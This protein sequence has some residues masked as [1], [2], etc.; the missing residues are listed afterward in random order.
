MDADTLN[1]DTSAISH[2]NARGTQRPDLL[3][4]I[5]ILLYKVFSVSKKQRPSPESTGV[6]DRDDRL[7]SSRSVVE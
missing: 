1:A 6:L 5:V 4:L 2:E 7:T 3:Q